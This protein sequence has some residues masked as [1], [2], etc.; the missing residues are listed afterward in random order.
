MIP[1]IIHQIWVGP[2]RIPSREKKFIEDIKIK[3]PDFE[4]MFWTNENIPEL[5][6]VLKEVYELFGSRGH[7]T[8]QADL[9]RIFIIREFGGLYLDA[10]FECRE[11]FNN[12]NLH[13]YDAFFG[14]HYGNV[15]TFTCGTFGAQKEHPIFDH[16]IKTMISNYP[17]RYWYG[18]SFYADVLKDYFK[19]EEKQI[20]H[21]EFAKRYFD[22]NRILHI[23]FDDFHVKYFWHHALYSWSP[24]GEKKFREGNYE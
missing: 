14:N 23:N 7:Y 22:P 12:F 24:D 4:H 21:E 13:D 19:C 10:D 17:E 18:P 15:D 8:F 11:G 1:K 3:H 16:F 2:Y 6:P 5:P 9:L 20:S